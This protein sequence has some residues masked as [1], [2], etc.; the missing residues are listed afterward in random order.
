MWRPAAIIDIVY[1]QLKKFGSL[2]DIES[3]CIMHVLLVIYYKLHVPFEY[4]N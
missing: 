3:F 4:H 2:Y 1:D